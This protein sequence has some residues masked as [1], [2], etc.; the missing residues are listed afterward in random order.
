MV[1]LIKQHQQGSFVPFA[2]VSSHVQVQVYPKHFWKSEHT[3]V[4]DWCTSHSEIHPYELPNGTKWVPKHPTMTRPILRC[5]PPVVRFIYLQ[6][7][8]SR[9]HSQCRAKNC[10]SKLTIATASCKVTDCHSKVTKITVF[11]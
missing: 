8:P 2:N 10:P 6:R 5:V 11:S 1:F 7:I 3:G 4:V 9:P